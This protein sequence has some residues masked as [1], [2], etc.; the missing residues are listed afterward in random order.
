MCRSGDSIIQEI[1]QEDYSEEDY[2][3]HPSIAEHGIQ[4]SDSIQQ[5]LLFRTPINQDY[6]EDYSGHPSIGTAIQDTH[7]DYSIQDTHQ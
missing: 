3:G 7:N 2:S 4:D 5:R 1:I 6:S